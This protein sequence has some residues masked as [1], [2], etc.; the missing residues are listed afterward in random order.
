[1]GLRRGGGLESTIPTNAEARRRTMPAVELR[2]SARA[3]LIST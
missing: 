1:M 3:S 2:A